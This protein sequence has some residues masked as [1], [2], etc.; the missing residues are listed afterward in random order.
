M[1]DPTPS[2]D[3]RAAVEKALSLLE[4]FGADAN[5]G[6]G[7]SALARRAGLSKSTAFRLLAMLE[8]KRAVERAGTAYRLGPLLHDLGAGAEQPVHEAVRDLLTP[9]LAELYEQTHQ[10]VH[11]AVLSGKDIVYLNK[12]QGHRRVRTPSKINGRLPAYCTGVGKVL[13]ART[14]EAAEST[15]RSRLV[16]WTPNT[17]TDPHV[18]E[19][20]LER[21]REGGIAYDDGESMTDLICVAAAVN[22]PNGPVA[23]LSVS[24]PRGYFDPEAQA[25]ALRRM[26]FAASQSFARQPAR[27]AAST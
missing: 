13:L 27:R 17:I 18:L 20:E 2:R 23:A 19:A 9:Y 24:G 1:D 21:I 16:G 8:R 25:A 5:T 7:V 26:A 6:L 3:D 15:L 4:A 12:L 14:P 22:G 10:T 11:L